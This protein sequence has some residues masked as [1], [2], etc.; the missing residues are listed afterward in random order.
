MAVVF[1]DAEAYDRFMGRWSAVLAPGFLDATLAGGGA[2]AVLLDVG[3]GPGTL[4]TV[5]L[6]RWPELTVVGVDPAPGFVE[7]A[8]ARLPADRARVE[9]GSATALP[10]PDGSVDAALALLVLNFV[11]DPRAGVAEMARVTRPGGTV[12]AAVWDYAGGMA[13]LRAFWDA[14]AAA[15]PGARAVDEAL[16]APETFGGLEAL[17][18]GAGLGDVRG[19]VLEVPMHWGSVD[20]FWA[21]FLDGIGPAGAFLGS[22]DDAGRAAVRAELDARLGDGPVDLVSTARWA[23]GT[24]AG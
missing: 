10:E 24:V 7:A 23:A 21:P 12:G 2:P 8:R 4:S 17:L 11:P 16:V 20:E 18:G 6:G 14:A 15:H 13:M 3:C 19:G 9:V 22:L 5:A 1:G